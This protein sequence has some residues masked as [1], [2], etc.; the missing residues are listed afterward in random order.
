MGCVFDAPVCV[1]SSKI[2]LKR[3]VLLI[4]YWSTFLLLWPNNSK[5]PEFFKL[6]SQTTKVKCFDTRRPG[7]KWLPIM[8][9]LPELPSDPFH[10]LQNSFTLKAKALNLDTLHLPHTSCFG[11]I[12]SIMLYLS[13]ITV[14]LSP[15]FSYKHSMQDVFCIQLSL[16]YDE[17]ILSCYD[18]R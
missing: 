15:C 16:V 8:Q 5:Y 9:L 11:Y 7:Y 13:W 6:E 14:L 4:V 2:L 17:M 10:I 12:Y 3:L 18:V 1:S